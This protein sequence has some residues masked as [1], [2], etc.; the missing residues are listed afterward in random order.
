MYQVVFHFVEIVSKFVYINT[1]LL[2]QGYKL[3]LYDTDGSYMSY[4]FC[5]DSYNEIVRIVT[6]V[7]SIGLSSYLRQYIC[8]LCKEL[9]HSIKCL[10]LK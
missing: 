4:I 5:K 6:P 8:G 9:K 3:D 10:A 7:F 1:V 2:L